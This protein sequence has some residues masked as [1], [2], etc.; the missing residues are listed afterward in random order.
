MKTF[1]HHVCGVGIGE[2]CE[3]GDEVELTLPG[4]SVFWL[5]FE[6]LDESVTVCLVSHV[7]ADGGWGRRIGSP[8][9]LSDGSAC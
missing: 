2:D 8:G 3:A 1:D 6:H 5:K 9:R 7:Q 4:Q